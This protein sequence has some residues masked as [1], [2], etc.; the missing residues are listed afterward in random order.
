[1]TNAIKTTPADDAKAFAAAFA[2]AEEAFINAG[3]IYARSIQVHGPGARE[4]FAAACP[5][6]TAGTWRRLEAVGNGS[7]DARLLTAGSCGANALRRLPITAQ[8][9]ALGTGVEVCLPGGDALRVQVDDLTPEQARQVFAADHV[10][11]LPAQRAWLEAHPA[12]PR[13]VSASAGMAWGV[14]AGKVVVNRP[15]SLT[16]VDL[17]R[18]LAELG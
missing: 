6:I 15:C 14:R 11:S 5:H 12:V 3:A 8:R 7:L 18:M 1:M 10:R 4:A 17:A 16:R 9:E 2:N 13:T